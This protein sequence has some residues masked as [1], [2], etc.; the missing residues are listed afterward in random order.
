MLT[1]L[2][3]TGHF[4]TN[5][6]IRTFPLL[7]VRCCWAVSASARS[8]DCTSFYREHCIKGFN[9][10]HVIESSSLMRR[11]SLWG[12]WQ[13]PYI[14]SEISNAWV[15]EHYTVKWLRLASAIGMSL[16]SRCFKFECASPASS[17]AV[18][19]QYFVQE[20]PVQFYLLPM[21]R[22]D[23]RNNCMFWLAGSAQWCVW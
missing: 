5:S 20:Y 8:N 12:L 16:R 6:V 22:V 15:K 9:F 19:Q 1:N 10:D 18:I 3:R 4:S 17:I 21:N 23:I 14:Q 13:P 2:R 7:D 11:L